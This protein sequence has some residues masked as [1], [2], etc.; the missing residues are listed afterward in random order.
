MGEEGKMEFHE[1]GKISR[2]EYDSFVAEVDAVCR[3]Y[4]LIIGGCGCCGSPYI[5]E[6]EKSPFEP[7]SRLTAV[8]RKCVA[9][10]QWFGVLEES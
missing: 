3:K 4:G 6:T 1:I 10:D 7:P 8:V 9:D 2:E 5:L